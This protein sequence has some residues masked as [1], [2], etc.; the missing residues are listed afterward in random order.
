MEEEKE[1]AQYGRL[2]AE[3]EFHSAQYQQKTTQM[4]EILTRISQGKDEIRNP[5]HSDE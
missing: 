3:R 5:E 2:Q 1:W 4:R